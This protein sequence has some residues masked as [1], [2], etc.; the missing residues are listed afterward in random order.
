MA[1]VFQSRVFARFK[2]F[3]QPGPIA[4]V[5]GPALGYQPYA[6]VFRT[7][8][9][10]LAAFLAR[11]RAAV[12]REFRLFL[13]SVGHAIVTALG[14][15]SKARVVLHLLERPQRLNEYVARQR[16]WHLLHGA[17]PPRGLAL[18]NNLFNGSIHLLG[19]PA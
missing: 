17:R 13:A 8:V 3:V 12:Q 15:L 5:A 19:A 9:E 10:T 18:V 4:S 16:A 7:E 11:V 6:C 1:H 2:R 14:K